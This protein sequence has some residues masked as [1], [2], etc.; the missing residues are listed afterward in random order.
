MIKNNYFFLNNLNNVVIIGETPIIKKIIKINNEINIRTIL[1]TSEDQ[2][3]NIDNSVK[4]KV[5]NKLNLN[6][7][8]FIKKEVQIDKTLFVSL[9]SRFI[10]KKKDISDF[11]KENLINFHGTRLPLDAGAGT[12][13]WKIMREDRIDT[14]LAHIIDEG[15]D[16]GG[17]IDFKMNIYPSYCKTPADYEKFRLI[18]FELFYKN[19]IH[20]IK[21]Q[22]KF[23]LRNQINFS[24]R[25]N[26][27]LNTMEN[28]YINWSLG[29]YDLFNFINAFDEPYSGASTFL[30]NGKFGKLNIKSVHLHGGDSSNHPFMAGLVTRH[31]KDW[32]VVSTNGKHMLLIEKILDKKGKNIISKIKKGDRFFTSSKDL[33]KAVSKRV[34]VGSFG[35]KK[36]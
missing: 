32:I 21:K 14:Q 2:S 10:F 31:D 24:G 17:I 11:F 23:F 12:Q 36:N 26:P 33:D 13:S 3:K 34:K 29:S 4:F 28:G 27:R 18:K 16:T 25:Y 15:I 7:K 1:I 22:K 8:N 20:N 19:L 35:F 6:F 5:F 9:G 30:N